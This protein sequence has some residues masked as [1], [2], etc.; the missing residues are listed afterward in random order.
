MNPRIVLCC[1]PVAAAVGCLAI[2]NE[3]SPRV[4]EYY[5]DYPDYPRDAGRP[6]FSQGTG[7]QGTGGFVSQPLPSPVTET[8]SRPVVTAKTP[9]PPVSGG[10]LLITHD[11]KRAVAADPD[12]DRVSIVGLPE[13]KVL[14]TV[15]LEAGDEPGRV[16]EDDAGR[17]HVVLRRGGAIASIDI[18]KG[19]LLGRSSVCGAP[20]GIAFD[21]AAGAL[22]VACAGGELVTLPAGGGEPTRRLTLDSDLRD[23]V[24]TAGG[25]VV[26]R[27][28]SANLIKLDTDGNVVTNVYSSGLLRVGDV[29][30]QR[31][32]PAVAWRTF[33]SP[34]GGI[35][36]LHQYDLAEPIDVSTTPTQTTTVPQP[37]GAPLDGCGGL[38]QPAVS[39][40]SDDGS[41]VM[42]MPIAAPILAV[43]AAISFDGAWIAMAH[44]GTEDLSALTA[45]NNPIL[46]QVSI[47]ASNQAAGQSD[48]APCARPTFTLNVP[49][50][51]TAVAFNPATDADAQAE[52]TWIAAQTREPAS[53][54]LFG[55]PF[56]KRV[57][58]IDLGG[59]SVLDTGHEIFHRDTG[60]GIAC[61][62]C[63]AEGAEDGRVW[64]F[65]P[66]GD[67]RTQSL[68]VGLT[69]TEPFHWDGDVFDLG[70]LIELVFVHRMGGPH[71]DP[72]RVAALAGWLGS[73][74][75]PARMVDGTSPEALR[76]KDLFES[77]DVGCSGCHAGDKFT[78]NQNAAVGTTPTGHTLQVPS[79]IGVGFRAP[80]LHTG[81]AATLRDRFDPACGGGDAHGTTSQLS[82]AQ[83]D[84]LISYLKS[85]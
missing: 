65:T 47:V 8:D 19:V 25:L 80:Y 13:N 29:D 11:G 15:A 36:I 14:S 31:V 81:C 39:T 85:L 48:A 64:K 32:E 2:N 62:S 35:R 57:Q 58:T 5:P 10:T 7:S 68:N 23:V 1:L 78:N 83:I 49:G 67:R 70:S 40:L 75:P 56:G 63:H 84:D 74:T 51:T 66:I 77:K 54:V 71:E 69:G 3:Q 61:A 37:Y 18:E 38:V 60:A 45:P 26:T 76:G 41:L 42:G 46:G 73:L 6:T 33:A 21:S 52:G 30:N 28:K 44:A 50:Q 82:V 72:S 9:P 22:H 12:R 53:L 79:L 20:R 27:F 34:T 16:V 4:R 59:D 17:A 43:D 24:V 55:D